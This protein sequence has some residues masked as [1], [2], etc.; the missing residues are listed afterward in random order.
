MC[1]L[2]A[3]RALQSERPVVTKPRLLL[4]NWRDPWHP[5]AGGAEHVTLRIAERLASQGWYIEWF[6]AAY[7]G[8]RSQ[9]T[10]GNITYVRGGSSA[11]VH[12]LA[13]IRYAWRRDFTVVVDQVNTIP[14]LTP[15]YAARSVAFFHQLAREVWLYEGGMFG[16]LGFLAEPLYLMPYRQHP[17]ITISPSSAESLRQIGLKGEARVIPVAVDEAAEDAVPKKRQPRDI[18]VIG[19]LTPSKRVEESIHAAAIL[20]Q[21]GWRGTLHI[22]GSGRERYRHR[23]ERLVEKRHLQDHVVFHG[24]VSDAKREALLRESS[25]LWMTSAREGWGL[26]VTEAARHGTPSVVYNVPGLQDSVTDGIT[27]RVIEP[28]PQYLAAAT[29]EVFESYDRF[30]SAALDASRKL[31]WERT[32][33]SFS[34]ALLELARLDM[35]NGSV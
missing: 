3:P 6:S 9:E 13:F 33:S 1:T 4:L 24:R 5:G 30:A 26:V 7:K 22:V 32:A 34:K 18:A 27:G 14:F 31:S 15:F 16:R 11:T 21:T 10:R 23:L 2:K 8:A 20:R 19:R 28:R 25:V 29:N 35:T 12:L 17:V